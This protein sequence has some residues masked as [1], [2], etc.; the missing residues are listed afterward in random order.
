MI[1]LKVI[2]AILICHG[3]KFIRW[4]AEQHEVK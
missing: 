1:I 2:C 3:N 4:V